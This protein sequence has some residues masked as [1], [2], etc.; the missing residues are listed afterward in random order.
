MWKKEDFAQWEPVQPEYL[1]D[2]G[3]TMHREHPGWNPDTV[4][5]NQTGRNDLVLMKTTRD[6]DYIYF[7]A[8]TRELLSPCTDRNW[9]MLFIHI[10]QLDA[11]DWEGFHFVV[12]RKLVDENITLLEMCQG[13][14]N[15]TET[16]R[17]SYRAEGKELHLT[18]PRC[19]IGLATLR[20]LSRFISSG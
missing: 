6:K 20:C 11:P 13:G 5:V 7:Y 12:N 4:Y 1:D 17:V 15:W 16:A 10:P 19:V 14:W 9:M 3:D 8:S 18:I 2:M